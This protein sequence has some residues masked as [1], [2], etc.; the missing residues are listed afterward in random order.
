MNRYFS[1]LAV[2]A[3]MLLSVSAFAQEEGTLNVHFSQQTAIPG[4]VLAPG[5]YKLTLV[6]SL[7]GARQVKVLDAQGRF[8]SVVPIYRASR[9]N[10][11]DYS[12]VKT[13]ADQ[14]GLSRVDTFY[15]P[16]AQDGFQLQYS[17]SDLQKAD[18]MA[19]QMSKTGMANGQ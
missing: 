7:N 15:F 12:V 5:S 4:R 2:F 3:L 13:V 18:L 8:I 10:A 9:I 6:E 16:A 11:T 14:A 1:N 17:K 19:Q